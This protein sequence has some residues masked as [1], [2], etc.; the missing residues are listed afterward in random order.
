MEIKLD[1]V[2]ITVDDL[3]ESINWYGK[4]FEF[5]LAER[6]VTS[7][8]RPWAI[9]ANNDFMICMSEHKFRKP[10]AENQDV[11][12]HRLFHFGI[13]V[14]DVKTW[15]ERVTAMRLKLFYGGVNE[16]PNSKS[17]YIRDP[18]GHLIEVSYSGNQPLKFPVKVAEAP[19]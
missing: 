5:Q 13:R 14:A 6:G 16:Y 10:A 4:A 9:V 8:R 3:T 11:D 12:H 2:N 15:E 19:A 1:H 17:W 7:E 18:S